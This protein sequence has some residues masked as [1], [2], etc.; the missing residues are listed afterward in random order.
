MFLS[1]MVVASSVVTPYLQDPAAPPTDPVAGLAAAIDLPTREARRRAAELLAERAEPLATWLKAARALRPRPT[2]ADAE[3]IDEHTLRYRTKLWLQ[4]A[5]RP[6]EIWVRVPPDVDASRPLPLLLVRHAAGGTGETAL[7][8]WAPLAERCGLV[9]AAPTETYES[10]R[11]E[12]WAYMPDAA[13][14][15]L[16]ALRFV[17]RHH[18]IDEARVFLGGVG[19]GGH[20]TWDVGARH[21]DLFAGLLPA[22]GSPRTGNALNE[23]N[24]MFLEALA[25]VPVR[26]LRWPPNEPR[27]DEHVARA[28]LL[29]QGLGNRAAERID[30]RDEADALGEGGVARRWFERTRQVPQRVVRVPELCWTPHRRDWGRAHWVEILRVDPKVRVPFPPPLSATRLRGRDA[31]G[32]RDLL[33]ATI[34]DRQP[35]LRI[36]ARGGGRFDVRDRHVHQLRILLTE[37]TRRD[38]I[39]I[40]WRGETL[41]KPAPESAA[42]LLREFVERFDRTF[43]PIAEVVLP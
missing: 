13:D 42:V 21:A 14:G 4:E 36:E 35:W 19:G 41:R 20:M 29:L 11:K 12:G 40:K 30:C 28:L 27:L 9:L 17:R 22:N 33:D 24:T 43:L 18:D 10:Y 23:C 32:Q 6:A 8:Q 26:A 37:T 3:R 34:R 39:E 15:V 5:E 1:A 7:H 2:P 38:A 16:E 31:R 25:S